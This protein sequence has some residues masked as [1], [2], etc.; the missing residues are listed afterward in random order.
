MPKIVSVREMHEIEKAAAEGGFAY[1][2]MMERAGQGIARYLLR[3]FPGISERRVLVLVGPGNNGGDGLVAAHYLA[4][5]GVDVELY[6]T[7]RREACDLNFSRIIGRIPVNLADQD[8]SLVL[9][10]RAVQQ[11]DLI[12]DAV[13]GTAFQ[14]PM[15]EGLGRTLG[16]VNKALQ[17]K[18]SPAL[19]VAVDCP[20][21]MECDTGC[22]AN[23]AMRADITL[24]LAAAKVGHFLSPGSFYM[25][26]LVVV[27][28]G[29][30]EKQK[31]MNAVKVEMITPA[32]AAALMP[33]RP[34]DSH[35]G[36]FGTVYVLAGSV[37]Y[38]G[39]PILAAEGAY[40]AGAGLV[41]LAVPAPLQAALAARLPEA[42]WTL[43]P[44]ELGVL[45]ESACDVL[46]PE[47]HVADV[48]ALGPGF[49]REPATLRF[50]ERLLS[51]SPGSSRGMI[52]FIH[53]E[54]SSTRIQ[55]DLP[56]MIID[57]DGLSLLSKI[58]SWAERI[59]AGSVLTP[60]PGEMAQ[61]TGIP[62]R[63]IQTNR[64]DVAQQWASRWGHV[65]VLKGAFTVTA[66]PD[67]RAAVIPI[68]TSALATAGTGDVLTGIIAAFVA[69]GCNA[70]DAAVLGAY[71]HAR[72]GE[73]AADA[74]G[75]EGSVMAGDVAEE[76][77]MALQDIRLQIA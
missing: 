69:Q 76:L 11:A 17:Q 47:L 3:E 35:K 25:G 72:A 9:L 20:S 64:V 4:E 59:P 74:V 2:A 54:K 29:L 42:T 18:P 58:D 1:A 10:D 22:V 55:G 24:T 46:L 30:S 43:L 23:E 75:Y 53:S 34:Q 6:L 26:R 7:H 68:A 40:R 36:T 14:L 27:S 33:A 50:L 19:V 73:M 44:H 16:A 32:E 31:E 38:P 67:G 5:A 48:I 12:L 60:H 57:A 71:V 15:R 52:G 49:G 70:Y 41:R 45:T 13:L 37:N 77:G 61:L 39:A 8:A 51:H 28:I 56:P 66:A 65:V 21:G 62:I 63:E